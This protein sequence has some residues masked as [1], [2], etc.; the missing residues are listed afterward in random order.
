MIAILSGSIAEK[1]SSSVVLD[2]NGVGYELFVTTSDFGVM[3]VGQEAK[4]YVYE[5]IREQSYDLY[6]FASTRSKEIFMLLLGVNGVGPKMA[7]SV[8]D[9][10]SLEELSGYIASGQVKVIQTANGVGKRIAERIAVELKDKMGIVSQ[11]QDGGIE[12]VFSGQTDEA[13]EALEA[14][15]F[16][17]EDAIKALRNVDGKLP[18]ADRVREA[19]KHK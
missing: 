9:L 14:L 7:L 2:V 8:L 12:P 6:G 11:A 3:R 13:I 17:G 5:H 15:G 4:F 16:S 1:L 10:G 18:T 19:L